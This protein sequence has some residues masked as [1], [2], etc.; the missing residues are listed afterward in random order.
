[1]PG[2][3]EGRRDLRTADAAAAPRRREN[4]RDVD[5]QPSAASRSPISATRRT[6]SSRWRSRKARSDGD[7]VSMK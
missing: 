7:A 4:R 6:R 5:R 2:V 1:V 3:D